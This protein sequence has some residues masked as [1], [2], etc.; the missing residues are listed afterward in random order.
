[1]FFEYPAHPRQ[2][3]AAWVPTVDVCEREQEIVILV[4]M[5]GVD[6]SDIQLA[7]NDGVLIISGLKRQTPP[8][9]GSARYHCVERTYGQFRREITIEAP[10][11]YKKA[12]AELKNGLMK[13]HLPKTEPEVVNIPIL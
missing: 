13:I 2:Q 9:Y 7:W 3:A 12:K 11:D 5:P 10:V 1:M 4:E 6:R 8:D